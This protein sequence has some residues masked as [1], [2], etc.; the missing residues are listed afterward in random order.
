MCSIL[1]DRG[2]SKFSVFTRGIRM[3]LKEQNILFF[4]RTMGLGGTENV[5]LQLC[6]VFKPYVNKIV[7]CSS[8]GVHEKDLK[9][10]GIM[11]Y[12]IPDI[13]HKSIGNFITVTKRLKRIIDS[14]NITVIHTHHRMAAFYCQMIRLN[15]KI[16]LIN[17]SHTAFYDKRRLTHIAF[18]RFKLIACGE[19]VKNS[20]VNGLGFDPMQIHVICN[21]IKEPDESIIPIPEIKKERVKGKQI[22]AAI[23][24]LSSEKGIDYLVKSFKHIQNDDV[25]CVI[26]GTGPEKESI[27]QLI[28]ELGLSDKFLML[29]YRQDVAN[30]IKQV[31]IVI[32]PSLQEGL[33]LVPIESFSVGRPVIGTEIDGTTEII[34]NGIN[35]QLVPPANEY[36][37]AKA[38]DKMVSINRSD[39]E[40][41]AKSTFISKYSFDVFANNYLDFY[42]GL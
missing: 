31:D 16:S 22:V 7:V 4:T 20:L 18:K 39:L 38:I 23:G 30:I 34:E 12:L 14:E 28:S 33:P 2:I 8:G 5:V 19:G 40:K 15:K 25:I 26:V 32:Q 10:M 11:H 41:N 3:E 9:D 21:G 1:P 6:E 27:E 37:L 35:G 17:T 42:R 29:G 13:E 24:R 36:E